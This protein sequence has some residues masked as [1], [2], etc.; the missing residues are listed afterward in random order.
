MNYMK[1]VI[2]LS[3]KCQRL[4]TT[5]QTEVIEDMRMSTVC[6][7]KLLSCYNCMKCMN[8]ILWHLLLL[9]VTKSDLVWNIYSFI[10]QQ[11]NIKFFLR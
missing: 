10:L 5:V 7:S 2:L 11:L 9:S 6:H 4:D 8:I 1:L 3:E